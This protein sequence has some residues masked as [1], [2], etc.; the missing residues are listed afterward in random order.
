[1]SVMIEVMY[2]SPADPRRE[3][4]VTESMLGLGGRL[5]FREEPEAAGTGPVCLTFEFKDFQEARLAASLL[6]S[7][8]EH[9]EGPM[10]Y[11]D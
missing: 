7:K 4:D 8:D 1:M 2:K 10:E 9:V 5:T 3:A 6:R 11:G